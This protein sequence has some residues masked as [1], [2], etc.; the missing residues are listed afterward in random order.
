MNLNVI[1]LA[2]NEEKVLAECLRSILY[3]SLEPGKVIVLDDGSTDKTPQI[4][5]DFCAVFYTIYPIHRS[6]EDANHKYTRAL[7]EA[8]KLIDPEFDYLAIVDAD[9]VLENHYFE[10]VLSRLKRDP[11]IGLTG[12]VLHGEIISSIAFGLPPHVFGANR[13]YTR[14]CWRDL[15]N[16]GTV[17]TYT[18]DDAI[19]TF[20]YLEA[21]GL[22]FQPTLFE[23]IQSWSLR[24]RKTGGP[25]MFSRGI[26]SYKM[27]YYFVY[28]IGRAL[29]WKSPSILAGFISAKLRGEARLASRDFVQ[30]FQLQKI[31]KLLGFK[32]KPLKPE[33]TV[34]LMKSYL[35]AFRRENLARD[36]KKAGKT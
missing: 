20:H 14:E 32:V 5:D 33:D 9:T 10:K 11:S 21:F 26:D 8:T 12:G 25:R 27:G 30:R 28:M 15:N 34:K 29:I 22:G 31:K 1:V 17:L 16:G 2:W 35:M 6:R 19:D 13:V 7:K 3:Q 4:I 23:D 24:P 36:W 18:C